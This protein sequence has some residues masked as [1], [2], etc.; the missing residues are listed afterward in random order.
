M[1]FEI[2]DYTNSRFDIV[3]SQGGI[4]DSRR[5]K[6][7]K[8]IK[9]ILKPEGI[10]CAGEMILFNNEVPQFIE[11]IFESSDLSLFT[12]HE[13]NKYYIERKFEI[14]EQLDLSSTL[15]NYYNTLKTN[16]E[17]KIFEL[18]EREKSYYKKLL[19]RI[20][21]EANV[22]LNQGGDKHIGFQTLILKLSSSASLR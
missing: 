6:I 17:K 2:T 22:Y 10:F 15:K 7:I 13:L 8:E 20:S 16:L 1:D 18:E 4:P 5:N 11:N 14:V 19:N 3:Y 9:R 21:H 12:A